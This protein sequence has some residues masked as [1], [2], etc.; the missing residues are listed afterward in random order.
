MNDS[1]EVIGGFPIIDIGKLRHF[2]QI[3]KLGNSNPPTFNEG[4]PKQGF[5][6]FAS[7]MAAI[8]MV[9]GTDVIKGGQTVSELYLTVTMYYLPGITPDMQVI[10][11]NGST[12]VIR[13]V[14]N[15]LEMNVYI[16]LNCVGLKAN[17]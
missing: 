14:E 11:D 16:V 7:A 5:T 2:I 6:T 9:S 17:G 13:A 10:S 1:Y 15:V 3:Q 8:D 12:Y 4:G